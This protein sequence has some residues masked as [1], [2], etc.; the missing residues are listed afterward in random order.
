MVKF[1]RFGLCFIAV[2]QFFFAIAFFFQ[3]PFAINLWPFE[4]TTPLTFIFISSIFAAAAAPTLWAAVTENYGALAG[5]GLDYFFILLPV[6]IL[7]F[8]AGAA[9]ST[10]LVSYGII[11]LFGALFGIGLL[12]WSLRY[13][14]DRSL[15]LPRVVMGSFIFFIIALAIVSFKLITKTPNAIPWTITPTLSLVI[16]WMFVG[17]AVYFIYG[18]LRPSWLN[19]AGQLLGFLFYDLVLIE[20]FITRLSAVSDEN[21]LGLYIYTA[22]VTVSGLIA[23]YYLFIN[24]PTRTAT[25]RL[26]NTG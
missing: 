16:G 4:G 8:Q 21:R 6:A 10:N 24:R 14:L 13:P 1:A 7:S 3:V 11:C 22:V 20:P 12:V 2:I 15:P 9:G 5:I 26:A 19:A 18:L 23:I 17:A 25:W